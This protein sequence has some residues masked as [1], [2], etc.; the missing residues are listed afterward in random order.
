M[1]LGGGGKG[2]CKNSSCNREA[3]KKYVRRKFKFLFLFLR[4]A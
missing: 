2:A 3:L 1:C 4:F